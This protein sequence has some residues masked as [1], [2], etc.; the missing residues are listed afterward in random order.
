MLRAWRLAGSVRA[1]SS[2]PGRST[3]RRFSPGT[4]DRTRRVGIHRAGRAAL[5]GGGRKLCCFRVSRGRAGRA[6]ARRRELWLLER[7]GGA[8]TPA[9]AAAG[10]VEELTTPRE[11]EIAA[12]AAGG[13]SNRDIAARLVV[14]VRRWRTTSNTCTGLGVDEPARAAWSSHS[15]QGSGVAADDR[16]VDYSRHEAGDKPSVVPRHTNRPRIEAP[17][18]D[19]LEGG[20]RGASRDGSD[21][22]RTRDLRRDSSAPWF[23]AR[24]RRSPLVAR[25]AVLPGLGLCR[26]SPPVATAAFHERSKSL[27]V[28]AE[29]LTCLTGLRP[30]LTV[31]R[32]FVPRGSLRPTGGRWEI[33]RPFR[34][35]LSKPYSPFR[36]RGAQRRRRRARASV[37]RLTFG[38]T[39]RTCALG[40]RTGSGGGGATGG[41]GGGGAPSAR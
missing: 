40:G 13:A 35:S 32:T 39:H 41:A 33:T 8:R 38:T 29:T 31:T 37:F 3:L 1:R 10:P 30:R 19:G 7:C 28:L 14:S 23:A 18:R 27:R 6:P 20:A 34:R 5:G 25:C 9:V 11:R 24:S 4:S 36:V 15:R 17:A 2:V 12:L 26:R 16:V 21:G 22:T